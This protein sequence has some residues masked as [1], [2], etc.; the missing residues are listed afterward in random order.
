VEQVLNWRH[1]G[2]SGTIKSHS[3][4]N[5]SQ[6]HAG[7]MNLY[8]RGLSMSLVIYFKQCLELITFQ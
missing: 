2:V 8:E 1:D 5:A 6:H 7:S 3:A 4:V